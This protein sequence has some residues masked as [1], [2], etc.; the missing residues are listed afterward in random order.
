MLLSDFK[1]GDIIK[2]EGG[3]EHEHFFILSVNKERVKFLVLETGEIDE[4]SF[5]TFNRGKLSEDGV[6]WTVEA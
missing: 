5:E 4:Y 1:V 2:E 3:D 6:I